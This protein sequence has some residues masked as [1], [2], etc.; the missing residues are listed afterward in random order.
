MA[1]PAPPAPS[2]TTRDRSAPGSAFEAPAPPTAV[3]V[4]PIARPSRRP[5]Y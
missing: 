3:G 5:P 4:R 1:D 2:G